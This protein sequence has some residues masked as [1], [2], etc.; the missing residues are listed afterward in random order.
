MGIIN[1]RD[2]YQWLFPLKN[3]LY[4]SSKIMVVLQMLGWQNS[5]ILAIAG[6]GKKQPNI[7]HTTKITP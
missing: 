2:K 4:P 5:E 3:Y 1:F 7:C 6:F